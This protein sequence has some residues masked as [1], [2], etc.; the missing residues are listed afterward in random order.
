MEHEPIR[1]IDLMER[2]AKTFADA[3][4]EH[5]EKFMAVVVFA[6]PGNNGG[7]ALAAARILAERGYS[8]EV[9]LFNTMGK[10]TDECTKNMRRLQEQHKVKKFVEVT[11][12]FEPPHLDECT[13][14][15]DGLFGSGLNRPLYGGFASLVKFINN[16]PSTIV[17][18]D[19]PSG[20]MSEDNTENIHQNIIRAHYTFALQ[21]KK[22]CMYL[23]DNSS[24]TGKIEVLD[25]NLSD[26][27]VRRTPTPYQ[28]VEREQ[29][30]QLLRPR[31]E[32]AHKG[33]MGHALII[34]GSYGMAGAAALSAKACMRT[35]A[36]KTTIHT[37][38]CNNSILQ[39][40][41]PEAV[42]HHD[43]E[44]IFFTE[45][46]EAEDF[47]AV[48]IG[49]GLGRN[50]ETAIALMTQIRKTTSPLILDADAINILSEHRAWIN[51]LPKEVIF[52]PHPKEFDR[53]YGGTC[54]GCYD[55][56]NKAQELAERIGAYIILKGHYSMLCT[57]DGEILINPTGNAGM[58]TAGSGDVLTGIITGLLA[59]G[60][61]RRSA[62][63]L[64]MYLHGLAGDIAA[65]EHGQESLIA[66]DIVD[67][68][69]KAYISFK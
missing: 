2:V 45:P 11:V 38:N 53:L 44:D 68:I 23:A 50:E 64:G 37:P 32:F 22:L 36:G 69:G 54:N 26:E 13:I 9:Y 24:Y 4:E 33:T 56:L 21:Q 27:F 57:P 20:L 3:F 66:S 59:R 5:W 39:T 41:V 16:S 49:P 65:E 35:G 60:Y 30:L 10:L 29:I 47:E 12:N 25:I 52:T 67:N 17:S 8:V 48:A 61:T 62:C 6:G 31:N 42:L 14:V 28:V 34:A 43:A 18:I 7:D 58:A 46:F 51:Q 1:P 15:I 19:L 55:R 40:L 63:I